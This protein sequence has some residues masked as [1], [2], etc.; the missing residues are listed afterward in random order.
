[1]HILIIGGTRFIGAHVVRRLAAGGHS[2]TVYHRGEHE[3]ELSSRVRHVH[4]PEAAMPVRSFPPELLT[5][6]PDVVIH[7][8]AMGEV[9]ARVAANF[10]RGHTGRMV[11]IS[12]G[13]VYLAFG[14]FSGVEPGPMES[15]LL[16]E[17][18]PLRTVLYPY[19]DASKAPD[20]LV[21]I[22][23]KILVE[24]IASGDR[25][26]PGTVLRLPKVYG[27][28]ENAD[29]ATVHA[30]RHHPQWRWTHGYVENVAAA[31]AL[32]A[33]HPAAANRTYNVGE[34]HTPTVG[35][36][37]ARLPA[38]SV[39]ASTNP[40]FNFGQ[41]IAYDTTRIRTELGYAE[42]VPEEEAMAAT[43]RAAGT[44]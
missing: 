43:S 14:R 10:F 7:M 42:V 20:D 15:G 9:D 38:S 32:A 19:R 3:S 36:R 28:E 26:L 40:K 17:D 22:Y 12:S 35:E 41:H 13:D 24:R 8:I 6:E 31:I 2:V 29:L 27:P 23:D 44:K 30:F 34:E 33:L 5:P 4:R 25:E 37:L 16:R 11:W 21:N 1:M 18:S 39:P